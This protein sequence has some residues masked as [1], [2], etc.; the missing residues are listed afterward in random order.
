MV[1]EAAV[2]FLYAHGMS[3]YQTK[4]CPKCGNEMEP[5]DQLSGP[6]RLVKFGDIRGDKVV[7]FYCKN[8]GYIELYNEKNLK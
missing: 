3:M 1:Q 2:D 8:C 7:P 6:I 5:Q 4:R